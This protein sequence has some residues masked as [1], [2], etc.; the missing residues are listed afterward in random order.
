MFSFVLPEQ[1]RSYILILCLL[2]WVV[3]GSLLGYYWVIIGLLLGGYWLVNRLV[4][5]HQGYLTVHWP[6]PHCAVLWPPSYAGVFGS[7]RM[8][9]WTASLA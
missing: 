3:I 8:T 4:D 2:H 1:K 6:Y 7:V 5:R 9:R